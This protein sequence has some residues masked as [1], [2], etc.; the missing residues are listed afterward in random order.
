MKILKIFVCGLALFAAISCGNASVKSETDGCKNN[1]VECKNTGCMKDSTCNKA[2]ENVVIENILSRRSIRKYKDQ[3]VPREVLE[4]IM[5]CGINAPNAM[6]KQSWEVRV[7]D[8]PEIQNT[9]K[10]VM[11]AAGGD[12]GAECFRGAPVWVFIARDTDFE[13]STIDCGLMAENIILSAH[14]MGV[15]SVCLGSPVRM[16]LDSPEK[17]KALDIL[18]FSQGYELCICIGLGYPDEAPDA[19]PRDITKVKFID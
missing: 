3:Q 11:S 14:S 7:V 16:V 15:G 18:G 8:N 2:A 13:F 17:D 6:N 5:E 10:G 4:T 12:F 9:I 19:K 1:C